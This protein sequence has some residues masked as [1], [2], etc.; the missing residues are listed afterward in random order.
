MLT[1]SCLLVE[2][3]CALWATFGHFLDIV[4]WSYFET[5]SES[6]YNALGADCA[7]CMVAKRSIPLPHPPTPI[8]S[9]RGLHNNPSTQPTYAAHPTPRR[10]PK[11]GQHKYGLSCQK[12]FSNS[13]DS[14]R[15]IPATLGIFELV[16]FFISSCSLSVC[17]S[18]SF[19]A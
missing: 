8:L 1:S 7:E 13:F 14:Y 16:C 2:H 12:L 4:C 9:H 15:K 6:R 11:S 3:T 10:A 18:R 5:T 19:Q 17:A